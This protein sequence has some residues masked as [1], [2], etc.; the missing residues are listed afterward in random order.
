MSGRKLRELSLTA[1]LLAGF[2]FLLNFVWETYHAE[3]LY[4]HHDIPASRYV[5]MM[6]HV[7]VNDALLVLSLYAGTALACRDAL[8]VRFLKPQRVALFVLLGLIVAVAVEVK[9]VYLRHQWSYL[10]AMPTLLGIGVSPLAQLSATGLLAVGI[11]KRLL[12]PRCP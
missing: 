2:T 10:P 3:F 4:R 7:A 1:A 6:T 5:P 8:W 12:F 9:G 11:T